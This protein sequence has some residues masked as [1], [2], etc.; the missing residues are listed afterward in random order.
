MMFESLIRPV[1]DFMAENIYPGVFL[2]ALLETVVPPVPSE[3]VFPLAGYVILDAG[4]SWL[5]V[6]AV[7]MTGGA[8][9]TLGAYVI[10]LAA[11]H[12]GR[13]GLLRYMGKIRISEERLAKAEGWFARYGDKSVLLGRC[14]PGIRELVSIPAG[15]LNMGTPKFLAYT[16]A[17]SCAWSTGLTAAG[18]HLGDA[19]LSMPYQV[20]SP[21]L[22]IIKCV[23]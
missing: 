14:I 20:T 15:I 5:H 1:L 21:T 16:F 11:R 23:V 8:G 17:G 6:P 9:A 18:Y 13:P 7:G 2:A 22:I 19:I 10:F 3:V 12:A 4:M